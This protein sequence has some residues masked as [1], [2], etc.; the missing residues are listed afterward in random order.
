[1]GSLVFGAGWVVMLAHNVVE[2]IE[3]VPGFWEK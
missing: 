1:M 3:P 2:H